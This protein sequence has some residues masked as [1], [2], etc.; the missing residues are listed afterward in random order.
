M[1]SD[2]KFLHDWKPIHEKGL[3]RFLTKNA[4]PVILAI[5]GT[6]LAIFLIYRRAETD[7]LYEALTFI[8]VMAFV[9]IVSIIMRWY[10]GEKRYREITELFE[11]MG[12]CPG[13]S[14]RVTPEH[15][16]CPYCGLLLRPDK[17]NR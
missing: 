13:C 11:A 6:N 4:L 10:S 16:K 7:I 9:I 1:N 14:A 15:T 17:D 2:E 3:L 12:R 8:G 5:A